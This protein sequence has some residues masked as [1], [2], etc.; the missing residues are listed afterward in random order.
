MDLVLEYRQLHLVELEIATG[1]NQLCAGFQTFVEEL[2]R[3]PGCFL[4]YTPI[5]NIPPVAP[6]PCTDNGFVT[7][8]SF[9]AL[10]KIT[11]DVIKVMC[12]V[13]LGILYFLVHSLF[14]A[15]TFNFGIATFALDAG[16]VF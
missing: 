4:C 13:Q 9:N 14:S 15:S 7:F 5:D 1:A 16:C 8:G 11:K 10:A 2:V 6:A 3:L 12:C